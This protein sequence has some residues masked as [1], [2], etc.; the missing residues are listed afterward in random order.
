[1]GQVKNYDI[2]TMSKLIGTAIVTLGLGAV[3]TGMK[4]YVTLVRVN[5]VA[6]QANRLYIASSPTGS[7]TTTTSALCSTA[8]KYSVLLPADG[9]DQF[10]NSVPDPDRPLFSFAA[11]SYVNMKTI[12][13][14]ATV[15][16][17]YY[18]M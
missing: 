18:D 16:M 9:V 2:K 1:M 14:N 17:Q 4:R 10:P 15:F 13:G 12:K 7:A 3:P 11:G 6:G 8:Q 5:N